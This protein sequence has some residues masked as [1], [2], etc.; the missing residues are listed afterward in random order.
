MS[1][2]FVLLANCTA[3]NKMFDEGG[4]AQPPEIPFQDCFSTKDAHMSRKRGGVNGVKQS[5]MSLRRNVHLSL[6]KQ[7]AIVIGPVRE[8]GTHE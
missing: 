2:D 1:V 7:M 3:S 5:G 4:Q 6:E 8:G